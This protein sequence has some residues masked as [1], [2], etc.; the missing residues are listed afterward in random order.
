MWA[1]VDWSLMLRL[2]VAFTVAS[3]LAL[4]GLKKHSLSSSGSA[5]AWIV[6]FISLVT[7]YRFGVLLL[8]FYYSSSKLTK[9][10][11]DVKAS[12]EDDHRPGG[13]R[14]WIQVLANSLLS[15]LLAIVYLVYIG[16]DQEI[17]FQSAS[18]IGNE[19]MI[20]LFGLTWG[21]SY[22]ASQLACMYIAHFGTA[23][24]DTWASE[25]GILA[26]SQPR[27]VTS[28]FMR[29]VP[30][31]TNGGM[32][33][34]GTVASVLG[35]GFIGLLHWLMSFVVYNHSGSPQLP[36]ILYG[37]FSG[38]F[39]SLLDSCLGATLQASYFDKE[40]KKIVKNLTAEQAQ[41][42]TVTLI[43]GVDVLS[44]EAVNFV[45]IAL[46]MMISW[47]FAPLFFCTLSSAHC[48]Y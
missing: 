12:L 47:Y 4:H 2:V 23:N 7:S 39:G 3:T 20:N 22:L 29:V 42:S 5:A 37:C 36:V 18:S 46:T 10:K 11:E 16:E 48:T 21:K 34:H 15:S 43:C 38:F 28:L 45:S 27:L 1:M 33:L 31:G 35:G 44:N 25:V 13:Q 32:S 8:M 26:P 6:G 17:N 30:A 40:K 19:P 24:G 14:N 9:L 41:A